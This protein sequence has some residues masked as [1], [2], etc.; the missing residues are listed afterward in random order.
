MNGA[1]DLYEK[2]QQGDYTLSDIAEAAGVGTAT[3]PYHFR[4]KYEVLKAAHERLLQPVVMPIV[5]GMKAKSYQ[6]DDPVDALI[7]Y[8]YTVSKVCQQNRAL[9]VSMI[10]T[11]F[12]TP[13]S[14]DLGFQHSIRYGN[15]WAYQD[16]VLG[17][18]IAHGLAGPMWFEPF[19]V[20]RGF[21]GMKPRADDANLID[22]ARV[23]LL[24]LYH[25]M[26]EEA[27]FHVTRDVCKRMLNTYA[28]GYELS[29]LMDR[30]T[31]IK[32]DVDA[33]H[34]DGH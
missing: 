2:Q 16:Q 9:T 18:Y 1:L 12:E 34:S 30:L 5:E 13:V 27:P 31:R 25:F 28:N 10:Q 24:R 15:T 4:T 21:L 14:F 20:D 7:R 29:D 17:G 32:E 33:Q 26:D 11:Y 23:L 8:V 3:I 22:D 19:A 6:P